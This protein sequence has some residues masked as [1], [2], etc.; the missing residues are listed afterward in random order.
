MSIP[1]AKPL[2]PRDWE[3]GY[4]LRHRKQLVYTARG[5]ANRRKTHNAIDPRLRLDAGV[6]LCTI[7]GFTLDAGVRGLDVERKRRDFHPWSAKSKTGLRVVSIAREQ[8]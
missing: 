3:T 8:T 6:S 4:S 2:V 5:P 1:L 7:N